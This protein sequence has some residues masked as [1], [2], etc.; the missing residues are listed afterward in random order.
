[1]AALPDSGLAEWFY[2]EREAC[3]Y[4]SAIA[5]QAGKFHVPQ[6][7]GLGAEPNPEVIKEYFAP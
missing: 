3:L 4:G 5:P 1:M 7:P 6:G 2:L